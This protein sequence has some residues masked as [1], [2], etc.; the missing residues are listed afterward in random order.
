MAKQG[1][2]ETARHGGPETNADRATAAA[3]KTGKELSYMLLLVVGHICYDVMMAWV[4][5]EVI[6]CRQVMRDPRGAVARAA[7]LWN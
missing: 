1:Y 2:K 4:D 6:T 5:R 7:L 3:T